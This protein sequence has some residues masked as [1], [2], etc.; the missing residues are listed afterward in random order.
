MSGSV[1]Y[2]PDEL[3]RTAGSFSR[4]VTDL[5]MQARSLRSSLQSMTRFQG[6]EAERFRL[7]IQETIKAL[8]R[9][10]GEV[11]QHAK[12]LKKLAA[13]VRSLKIR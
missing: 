12:S 2:D 13:D 8:E 10:S 6:R 9:V 1:Q 7:R 3:E 4:T 5:T 11:D